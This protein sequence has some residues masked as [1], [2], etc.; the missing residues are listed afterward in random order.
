MF[1]FLGTFLVPVIIC[2]VAYWNILK[3]IRRQVSVM[4]TSRRN[5]TVKPVAGPSTEPTLGNTGSTAH[6]NE[7]DKGEAT[8]RVG[9]NQ[10]K[11]TGLS[12]AKINVIRTMISIFVCFVAC[13]LPYD[14]YFLIRSLTVFIYL[15]ICLFIRSFVRLLIN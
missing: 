15:F 14:I 4:P 11:E 3:A 6:K 13:L 5:V 12:K 9:A 7:Q 2:V 10:S 8:V 1:R